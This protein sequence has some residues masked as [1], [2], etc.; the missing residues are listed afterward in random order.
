MTCTVSPS[1]IL[2]NNRTS[3]AVTVSVGGNQVDEGTNAIAFQCKVTHSIVSSDPQYTN[4]PSRYM[5]VN[6]INDDVAD[7]Y[8]W[9]YN[10]KE[11]EFGYQTRFVT[12]IQEGQT[13]KYIGLNTNQRILC[14]LRQRM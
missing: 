9:T 14:V 2:F 6:V 4:I 8:L 5:E 1:Q 13:L 7:A 10:E 11:N 12:H 3:T